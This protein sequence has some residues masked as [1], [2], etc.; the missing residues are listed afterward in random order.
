MRERWIAMVR[1][2]RKQQD[3][4]A[5][6][7]RLF[8]SL[9][10]DLPVDRITGQH[11]RDF[12]DTLLLCPRNAPKSLANAS[13][14]ELTSWATANPKAPK[15]GRNTINNKAL[16]AISTLLVQAKRDNHVTTNPTE[17]QKLPT[18]QSDT[19]ER[20]PHTTDELNALFR[21][22]VYAAS[23]IIP[24]AGGGWAA[25]WLPFLAL[26]TGCRL[27]ELGQAL[28]SD[29][30]QEQGIS[31]L[32]ITTLGDDDNAS[33]KALKSDAA[34]RRVPL[35]AKLIR[36]GFLDYVA[37]VKAR[38]ATRLFPEL[39]EYRGRYTKDWSKWWGRWLDKHVTDDRS[40]SFHSLR[41]SWIAELRRLKVPDGHL[42]EL[43][44]HAQTDITSRYG[45]RKGK[46]YELADL[47]EQIQ[48]LR[49]DGL[50]LEHL[51]GLQPWGSR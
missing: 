30:R 27:E 22:S 23:P 9:H 8:V 6:Y 3:D 21:T 25:W 13:L 37:F 45:R 10:G 24:K 33:G 2:T 38:G 7:L 42:K 35:H 48:S 51:V 19:L 39:R 44:G 36:L 11:V 49:F 16:G 47:D 50:D 5:R 1:P 14:S 17:K 41:H 4:N 26:F 20:Q 29:V 34:R 28:V 18:R 40:R 15:L 12:R 46:L 32:E 31:Y 43:A